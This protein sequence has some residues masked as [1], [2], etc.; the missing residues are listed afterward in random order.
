[1]PFE[2]FVNTIE[3]YPY[4]YI[5][6]RAC[7]EFPCATPS[8]W[9]AQSLHKPA[10]PQTTE[11]W[12]ALLDATVLK[13]GVMT[14]VFHPYGWSTPEQFVDLIDHAT[15]TYGTRVKFLTFREAHERLT[16]NLS[17]GLPLR[18]KDGSENGIRLIDLNHDGYLD[19]VMTRQEQ[20]RVWDSKNR[21]WTSADYPKT[22]ERADVLIPD[23]SQ[24]YLCDIDKDGQP[25]LIV[26]DTVFAWDKSNS[27]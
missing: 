23:A 24:G 10:N 4:P 14:M 12:K 17:N 19:V 16:K 8:D 13:Q 3:D 18:G 22:L 25:E 7:W 20:A 1:V 26:V 11:D 27:V 9:Q 2:A 5:I 15:K 21:A 6:G